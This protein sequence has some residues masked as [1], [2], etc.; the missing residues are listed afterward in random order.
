[1][2]SRATPAPD[3]DLA[4]LVRALA[5]AAAARDYDRLRQGES[6]PGAN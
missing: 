2:T 5:R 6:R 4:E 1:M 3:R